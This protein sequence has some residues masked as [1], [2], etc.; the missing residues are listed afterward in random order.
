[1]FGLF[2]CDTRAQ[3]SCK[4]YTS[5]YDI[6]YWSKKEQISQ[7]TLKTIYK[8]TLKQIFVNNNFRE[9]KKY[10]ISQGL[11]FMNEL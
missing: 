7:L 10:C 3:Y 11:I 8:N 9:D 2:T 4:Q 6:L 5:L 1:M